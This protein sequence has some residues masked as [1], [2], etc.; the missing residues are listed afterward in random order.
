M[1]LA[2]EDFR[3]RVRGFER[4]T[5]RWECQP[6]HSVSREASSL[7]A[8][9]TGE[10]K[11]ADHNAAW[12]ETVRGLVASG[13]YIGRVRAVR[14]PLTDYQRYQ[15]AWG[16]PG[17]VEAGE[18]IR[19]LDVTKDSLGLPDYDFWLL[20]EQEVIRL[21]FDGNGRVLSRGPVEDPDLSQ[22]LKWRDAALQH[23]THV[24]T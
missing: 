22:Y 14:H 24:R 20:E 1:F 3:A 9:L 7:A 10:P 8:F 13:R 21:N 12:R 6:D 19:I 18:D 23:A 16:I 2:L 11:P 15:L 17:N 5:W 4:S